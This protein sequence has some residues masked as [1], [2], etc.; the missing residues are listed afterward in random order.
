MA[1][2]A[3]VLSDLDEPFFDFFDFAV[4]FQSLFF[5]LNRLPVGCR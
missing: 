4:K 1:K 5:S 2:K 3:Q